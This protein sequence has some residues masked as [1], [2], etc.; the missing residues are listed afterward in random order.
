MSQSFGLPIKGLEEEVLGAHSCCRAGVAAGTSGTPLGASCAAAAAPGL[1]E[2][3]A[4]GLPTAAALGLPED[5]AAGQPEDP[6]A[7]QPEAPTAGLPTAATPGL[8]SIAAPG[9]PTAA[10]QLPYMP[11]EESPSSQTAATA[12]QRQH[13]SQQPSVGRVLFGTALACGADSAQPSGRQESHAGVAADAA[14]RFASFMIDKST[15]EI[16]AIGTLLERMWHLC[17]FHVLQDWDRFL[18]SSE[19]GVKDKEVRTAVLQALKRLSQTRDKEQF[20]AAS[21]NF[22]GDFAAL[23]RVVHHYSKNWEPVAEH[24]A[25][26]GRE[27]IWQMQ[28]NTN[29]FLERFF[30]L[31]KHSF[32]DGQRS[33]WLT[34]LMQI[35]VCKVIPHYIR[36]RMK[37]EAGLIKCRYDG[38]QAKHA[39]NVG[40]LI[41]AGF[42]RVRFYKFI[43][44]GI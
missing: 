34:Q 33:A 8:P 23:P 13:G 18:K 40:V 12:Q 39:H 10:A 38:I 21:A 15:A 17:I 4:A 43:S 36:D 32:C 42:I 27:D 3:P 29:N 14:F 6:A 7:G 1:P 28:C 35:I 30:G 5:P 44:S 22:K 37:K 25:Q 11:V 2:F 26:Y 16:C 9:L 19:A 41:A 31:F 20:A 24:W